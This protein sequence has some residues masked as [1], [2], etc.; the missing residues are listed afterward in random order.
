V[1][2]F[3]RNVVLF[4]DL[5]VSFAYSR[6]VWKGVGGVVRVAKLANMDCWFD[7]P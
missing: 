3:G 5:R 7:R 4:G 2:A 1:V 6:A